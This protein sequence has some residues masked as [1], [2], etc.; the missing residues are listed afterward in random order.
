M[1]K[2]S[3]THRLERMHEEYEKL[4]MLYPAPRCALDFSSPLE[5][6]V[7][8]VLSAQTT[9][10]RVNMVTP[11]LFDTYPTAE[12]LAAANPSQLEDIIHSTG[13]YHAKAK[14]LIG[15]GAALVTRFDS[16]VPH[17]MDELTSLPGVGRK[18]ANVVLGNAFRIPGFPVDT[19]V[20]RLTRRLRWREDWKSPHPDPV[21]IEH[22][23][24]SYFPPETWTD[25]SH[26][27][28]LH[29]R[30]VCHARKPECSRCP[31]ADTCPS[32]EITPAT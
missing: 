27:L 15:L 16:V 13:F 21:H 3:K 28:I 26:R 4:C 23:I 5:L 18:T 19:H 6:L 1:A 29:G 32:A 9:D 2:E 12:A 17:T 22:E 8:T 20:I 14:H 24:T 31:L 25:L 30:A 7:A 11:E 10:V